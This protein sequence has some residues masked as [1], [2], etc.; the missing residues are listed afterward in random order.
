LW[1]RSLVTIRDFAV[2]YDRLPA[3]KIPRDL[4]RSTRFPAAASAMLCA[5]G[6]PSENVD[7]E[8]LSEPIVP[9]ESDEVSAA[10]QASPLRPRKS[11]TMVRMTLLFF[12]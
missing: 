9:E 8:A 4:Q 6:H 7:L 11:L 10:N 3:R 1:V 5:R 12:A 2:D